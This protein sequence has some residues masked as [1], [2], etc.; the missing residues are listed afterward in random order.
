MV[1]VVLVMGLIGV[2][3][4]LVP[5]LPGHSLVEIGSEQSVGAI[6]AAPWGSASILVI[7]WMYIA[8]MGINGLTKATQIA[9]L[10]ANYIAHRLAPYYPVLYKGK[11]GLVAHEMHSGSP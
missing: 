10:N 11:N 4:H 8:M 3:D 7:S 6:A 9:I 1:V 5:F 2:A